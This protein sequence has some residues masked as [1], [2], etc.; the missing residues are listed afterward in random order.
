MEAFVTMIYS[1][2]LVLLRPLEDSP[3][4]GACTTGCKEDSSLGRRKKPVTTSVYMPHTFIFIINA[5]VF[6]SFCCFI[7]YIIYLCGAL[8]Q[9]YKVHNVWYGVV[10]MCML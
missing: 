2:S 7:M 1:A 8:F 6:V 5:T 10:Y 4:W 3:K 9:W